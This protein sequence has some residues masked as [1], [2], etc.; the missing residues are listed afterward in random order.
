MNTLEAITGRY[1][2]RA[3]KN[4]QITEEDL[5]KILEA[6]MA[7]PV[8]SAAYDTL[9]ITIVRKQDVFDQI[10][11]GVSDLI[12]KMMGRR[13]DKNFGAPT[14]I[15]ISSKP[16]MMSG[17]EY[18]NASTV[19]E[20]MAIAAVSLGI[21]NIIWGAA[22]VVVAQS[23]KLMKEL[24]IPEGFKPVLCLSLGYAVEKEAAKLHSISVN[25]VE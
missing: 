18:A 13:M 20:N 7:A 11:T 14:M 25:R 4:E 8:A 22:A 10:N 17:M 15:F 6:G 19:L 12:F 2:C 24:E 3:Y 5:E 1:S 23:E 21:D 9:H 16:A